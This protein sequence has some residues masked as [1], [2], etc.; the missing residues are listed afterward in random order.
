MVEVYALD[1]GSL[2]SIFQLHDL[3]FPPLASQHVSSN[4]S[5]WV[6]GRVHQT[7]SA[8]GRLANVSK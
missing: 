1:L 2:V 4:I 7:T 5:L 8:A 3:G 6:V